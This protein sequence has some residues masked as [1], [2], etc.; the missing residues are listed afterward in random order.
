MKFHHALLF[1]FIFLASCSRYIRRARCTFQ[2]ADTYYD[3]ITTA[4]QFIRSSAIYDQFNTVA[5][6][7]VLWLAEP[8]RTAYNDLH[9]HHWNL[10]ENIQSPAPS[11]ESL[12]FY[13]LLAPDYDKNSLSL[14]YPYARWSVVLRI[15]GHTYYPREIRWEDELLPEYKA[16][17]NDLASRHKRIYFVSFEA[18]DAHKNPLITSTTT[19][20]ELILHST[21]YATSI[22][23]RVS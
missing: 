20:L 13:I 23:W 22:C 5:L 15:D 19:T 17:F 10:Q 6:F 11:H 1:S 12:D 7:D 9:A 3:H 21:I 16:I 4:R 18:T 2:Q 8:V 14:T